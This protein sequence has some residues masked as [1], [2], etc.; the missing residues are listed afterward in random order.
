MRTTPDWS[1]NDYILQRQ[2]R[3]VARK[4]IFEFFE[5]NKIIPN[6]MIDIS[7]GLSSEIIHICNQSKKGAIIY[8]DT[9]PIH[10]QTE[11]MA[12]E[13]ELI[14]SIPAMNGGEDYEL[15]FTVPAFLVAVN[16]NSPRNISLLN[17]KFGAFIP[18][19]PTVVTNLSLASF[20]ASSDIGANTAY[21]S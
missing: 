6:S 15:L 11:K 7:D 9:L 10:E 2:L 5:E 19:C 21:V 1:G 16:V 12:K 3:P 8:E 20:C 13:M 4:D 18:C 14:P 17:S